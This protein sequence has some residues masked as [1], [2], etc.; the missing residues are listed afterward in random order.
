MHVPVQTQHRDYSFA[1]M[2]GTNIMDQTKASA[3]AWFSNT[4]RLAP[5][6]KHSLAVNIVRVNMDLSQ[7][8]HVADCRLHWPHSRE[9]NNW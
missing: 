1:N 4:P 6:A 8:V 9:A 3:I 5:I 2:R 7:A